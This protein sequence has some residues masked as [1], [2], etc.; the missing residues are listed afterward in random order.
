MRLGSFLLGGIL[1][2]SA[3]MMMTR[4]NKF[5]MLSTL[6]ETLRS[7]NSFVNTVQQIWT[8]TIRT[9]NSQSQSK[10]NGNSNQSQKSDDLKPLDKIKG[11]ITNNPNVEREVNEILSESRGN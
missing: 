9:S 10:L 1:G 4:K 6:N 2:A 11:M 8:G 7:M 5:F 3:A